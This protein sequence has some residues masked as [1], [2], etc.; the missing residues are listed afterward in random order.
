MDNI[1]LWSKTVDWTEFL[2]NLLL[3]VAPLLLALAGA[4]LAGTAFWKS[5]QT[6]VR[7]LRSGFDEASDPAVV[8]LAQL[9]KLPAET[10]AKIA[11]ALFDAILQNP[12]ARAA[13]EAR[14]WVVPPQEVNIGG[15]AAK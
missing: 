6:L 12:E 3:I 9:T 8:W 13:L 2:I 15:E 11:V 1:E 5:L 10:V 7:S 14:G 4:A